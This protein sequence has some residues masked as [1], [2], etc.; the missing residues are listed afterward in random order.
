MRFLLGARL[1]IFQSGMIMKEHW[2]QDQKLGPKLPKLTSLL[3][4]PPFLETR[5]VM[6]PTS[7]G[8]LR[9]IIML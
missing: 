5:L 9:L 2:L 6:V 3:S 8:Y 7:S 4:P 1:S